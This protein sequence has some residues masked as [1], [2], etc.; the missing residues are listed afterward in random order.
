M[1]V[2]V[3]ATGIEAEVGRLPVEEAPEVAAPSAVRRAIPRPAVN[4]D[5]GEL[6]PGARH[7]VRRAAIQ[8]P[9]SASKVAKTAASIDDDFDIDEQS[10]TEEARA[11]LADAVATEQLATGTDGPGFPASMKAGSQPIATVVD[12]NVA[13]TTGS[14]AAVP[15]DAG[16]AK[17]GLSALGGL[18]L[19]RR[20]ADSF[21]SAETQKK[22]PYNERRLDKDDDEDGDLQIPAFLRRQAN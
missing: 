12:P 15:S 8:R 11:E 16:P 13:E 2:S 5:S 21:G 1:R 17:R 18:N 10:V 20:V 6:R 14:A 4:P 9:A 19:I 22:Q 3:V 7:A